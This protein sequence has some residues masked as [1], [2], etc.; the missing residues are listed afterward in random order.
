MDKYVEKVLAKARL[1]TAFQVLIGCND[2]TYIEQW[3]EFVIRFETNLLKGQ[4]LKCRDSP[5]LNFIFK[6]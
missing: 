2:L 6:F 4:T 3:S 5:K 1:I